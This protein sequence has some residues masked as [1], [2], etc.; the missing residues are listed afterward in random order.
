M[1][2]VCG[3]RHLLRETS[4]VEDKGEDCRIDVYV[5]VFGVAV[6]S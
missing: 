5:A 3:L 1:N 4:H 6:L 2:V